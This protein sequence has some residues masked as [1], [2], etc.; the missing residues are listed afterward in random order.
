MCIHVYAELVEI[1]VRCP[2]LHKNRIIII[3][4]VL[5]VYSFSVYIGDER[6]LYKLCLIGFGIKELTI[7]QRGGTY[8]LGNGDAT[9]TVFEDTVEMETVV[10]YA[11]IL[12]GPFVYSAGYKPASVVVYLNLEGTNL[13]KP[14]KLMLKHWCKPPEV[15]GEAVLKL[16]RAPHTTGEMENFCIFLYLI[17]FMKYKATPYTI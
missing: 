16:L 13:Q 11:V 5:L 14:L 8:P 17:F 4:D 2:I 6:K 7:H 12:H 3:S 9:L 1:V 10:R 15:S